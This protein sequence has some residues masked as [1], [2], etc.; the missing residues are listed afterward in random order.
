MRFTRKIAFS[1]VTA[2]M[3]L[4]AAPAL[5]AADAPPPNDYHQL[6]Y[7]QPC[8]PG[9]YLEWVDRLGTPPKLLIDPRTGRMHWVGGEPEFHGWECQ[10]VQL[11][12]WQ[13]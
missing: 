9:Q 8:P 11:E 5:A 12:V 6:V 7:N 2:A 13:P 10:P 1:V 3:A 4:G